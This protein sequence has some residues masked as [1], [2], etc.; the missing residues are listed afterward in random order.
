MSQKINV[1]LLGLT[2]GNWT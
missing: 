2:N 1:Y